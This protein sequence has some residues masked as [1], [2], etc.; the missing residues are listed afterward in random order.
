MFAFVEQDPRVNSACGSE[1]D[2]LL[3]FLTYQRQTL[4]AKCAA[5]TT[6]RCHRARFPRL[7]RSW[8]WCGT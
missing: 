8:G 7:C 1:R 4:E 2:T 3:G 5:L 6:S